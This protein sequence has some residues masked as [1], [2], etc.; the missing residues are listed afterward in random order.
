VPQASRWEIWRRGIGLV[1]GR[2]GD[3]LFR[4]TSF[5][6]NFREAVSAG[7]LVIKKLRDTAGKPIQPARIKKTN[8]SGARGDERKG[9]GF[10][11]S[12]FWRRLGQG[13]DYQTADCL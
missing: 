9:D 5:Y 11:M 7:F 12:I 3:S 2:T 8:V 13:V 1:L 10:G 6:R 4:P